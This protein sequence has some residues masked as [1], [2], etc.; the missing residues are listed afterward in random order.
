MIMETIR[1]NGRE[2][3][4]FGVGDAATATA[5]HG[6]VV[7]GLIGGGSALG[8]LLLGAVA[9]HELGR[10][11]RSREESDAWVGGGMLAGT[12]IGSGL[13]SALAARYGRR[14]ERATLLVAQSASGA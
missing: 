2:V 7:P 11:A 14:Q 10:R 13:G 4:G 1:F 8:G 5:S 9:G 6:W 12:V 3:A